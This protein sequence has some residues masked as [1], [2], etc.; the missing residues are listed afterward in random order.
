MGL[1]TRGGGEKL[2]NSRTYTTFITLD[3]EATPASIWFSCRTT[4]SPI[5]TLHVR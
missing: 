5:R 2:R 4:S 3:G 1:G